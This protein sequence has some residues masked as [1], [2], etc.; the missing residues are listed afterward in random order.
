MI[1]QPSQTDLVLQLLNLKAGLSKLELETRTKY[2]DSTANS[3]IHILTSYYGH[4]IGVYYRICQR[5]HYKQSSV[6]GL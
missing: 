2:Y 6:E 1:L 5:F 3:C 4:M